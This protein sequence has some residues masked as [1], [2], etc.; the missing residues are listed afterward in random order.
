MSE[1]RVFE[2]V[3]EAFY[4]EGVRTVFSL[5]GDG[6]M[7]WEAALAAYPDVKSVHARHEHCAVAMATAYALS[8][9][10]VGVASVTCGP[11]L[12]QIMTA[13]TTA[14]TARVPMVI[15]AG[16]DPI[17]APWYNQRI[18]QVPLVLGT[19]ALYVTG[20]SVALAR[21]SVQQ[22]FALAY[23]RRLPVVL[24]IPLDL[25]QHVAPAGQYVPSQQ[26]L[27]TPRPRQPHPDEIASAVTQIKAAKR[28]ILVGGRGA[29]SPDAR[30]AAARFA[31][32]ANAG[33]S[34][35][36]PVRGLYNGNKRYLG[37]C[38]GYIHDA[39]REAFGEADLVI[40]VGASLT[41]F[42][43]DMNNLFAPSKV[44]AI[45]TNPAIQQGQ[46]PASS[47]VVADSALALNAICDALEK[48]GVTTDASWD[49]EGYAA[50]VHSEP[51]DAKTEFDIASGFD[52]REVMAVI[53][54]HV[55]KDWTHVSSSGHCAYFAAHLY[56]RDSDD[57][58]AIREFG[59]IGNGLSYAI[60]RW[61]A[62]PDKPLM[63]TDGDGGFLMH[64]QELETVVRLGAKMLIVILNDGAY[65][66]EI[67]KLRADGLPDSGAVFG[68]GNLAGIARGFGLIGH[69]ITDLD[70]IPEL[71]AEFEASDRTAVWDIPISQEVVAPTMRNA[72]RRKA[73]TSK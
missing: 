52:P 4:A 60:G 12:T 63:L 18:D 54:R 26:V 19:G 8:T 73:G 70:Q 41:R 50:R 17:N 62:Q 56:G 30:S 22:A 44:L 37:I 5:T 38:G 31:E 9:G 36:L 1:Q 23:E 24:G 53:D 47:F 68:Q 14:A 45:N 29:Q 67:H 57:F 42:T 64:M 33:L 25:Q 72:I 28:I 10:K 51:V 2:A 69:T 11:G 39:A 32:L 3:A 71:L 55:P 66:S 13:L 49:V 35:T 20:R 27:P 16:E 6:N 61:A 58:L 40:A 65:G 43:S 34:A 7:H 21:H 59:A 46:I 48:E 15:F